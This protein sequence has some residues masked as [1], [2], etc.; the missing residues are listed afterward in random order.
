MPRYVLALGLLNRGNSHR[1]ACFAANVVAL[2]GGMN[3]PCAYNNVINV[4][5]ALRGCDLPCGVSPL[6]DSA[7]AVSALPCSANVCYCIAQPYCAANRT[8]ILSRRA[9]GASKN[10]L[11]LP[12]SDYNAIMPVFLPPP[13]HFDRSEEQSDERSG[14]ISHIVRLFL[15]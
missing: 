6:P 4:N 3:P 5:L 2:I 8:V 13:C 12:Q 7:R 14:E 15:Q 1:R 11:R 9:C 10:L